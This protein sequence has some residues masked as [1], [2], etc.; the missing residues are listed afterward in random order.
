MSQSSPI[1][2]LLE[3][4]EHD[5]I[6]HVTVIVS[7]LEAGEHDLLQE[8]G[9]HDLLQEAGEH[10]LL[11]EEATAPRGKA[12]GTHVT[13]F[14][15]PRTAEQKAAWIRNISSG[16]GNWS[17]SATVFTIERC[18]A[19]R[20]A[21]ANQSLDSSV[22]RRKRCTSDEHWFCR[23][24]PASGNKKNNT[25]SQLRCKEVDCRVQLMEL[26]V[27]VTGNRSTIGRAKNSNKRLPLCSKRKSVRRKLQ[28]VRAAKFAC[29]CISLRAEEVSLTRPQRTH[30]PEV[31]TPFTSRR[32]VRELYCDS[33]VIYHTYE[34]KDEYHLVYTVK[35][36][37]G[38]T[39]RLARRSDEALGVRV[40]V[41]RIALS[42]L[43][44]GLA[45]EY[46]RYLLASVHAADLPSYPS[47]PLVD[48]C[49]GSH[50][51]PE[52]HYGKSVQFMFR[53]DNGIIRRLSGV[54]VW[55]K[56][57]FQ[58]LKVVPKDWHNY[59][60][61]VEETYLNLLALVTPIIKENYIVMRVAISPHEKLT[62]HKRMSAEAPFAILKYFPF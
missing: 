55:C 60:R 18:D 41:V 4:G 1:H 22:D 44:L 15:F 36:H 57:C 62:E 40:S 9:E 43:D 17:P 2:L 6:Y 20:R 61:M 10:H 28:R 25:S 46:P 49:K 37:D 30:S 38:N 5:L 3:A 48:V 31:R 23:S 47:L 8:A 21:S 45:E 24:S 42:L 26:H 11:Q 51:L 12:Q 35:R 13:V 56:E 58:K 27:C 19:T 52:I 34:T 33:A 14:R 29:N 53:V 32:K 50:T 16:S 7:T 54:I 59:L 39:A